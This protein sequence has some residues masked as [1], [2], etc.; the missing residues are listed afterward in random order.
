M[1]LASI[2]IDL[3]PDQLSIQI[4]WKKNKKHNKLQVSRTSTVNDTLK[5]FDWVFLKFWFNNRACWQ[6]SPR[7]FP[8]RFLQILSPN[9]IC[10]HWITVPKNSKLI[11]YFTCPN[12]N[13][14][15]QHAHSCLS[16]LVG[17]CI[18][19]WGDLYSNLTWYW[20]NNLD[21]TDSAL[22]ETLN[23][24][25]DGDVCIR[26][27]WEPVLPL[28]IDRCNH[29]GNKLKLLVNSTKK[30]WSYTNVHSLKNQLDILVPAMEEF[31]MEYMFWLQNQTLYS[32]ESIKT[33]VS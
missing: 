25:G 29:R 11:H 26:D 3:Q 10:Y 2:T 27:D 31:F 32:Y 21:V 33:P 22:R 12:N 8:L 4:V 28:D 18:S 17:E 23:L 16:P 20:G 19:R 15:Y 5:D 6:H 1:Q 30:D 7:Q 9:L 14:T 24:S 13:T